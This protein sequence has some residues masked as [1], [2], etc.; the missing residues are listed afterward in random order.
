M[1]S[2]YTVIEYYTEEGDIEQGT[3]TT[4]KEAIK[5]LNY[6]EEKYPR[7]IFCIVESSIF[8]LGDIR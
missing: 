1:F 8:D 7:D 2:I 3:F 4:E 5:C 6:L